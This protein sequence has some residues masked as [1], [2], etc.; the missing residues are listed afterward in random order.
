[1]QFDDLDEPE[2]T[3]ASASVWH[4]PMVSMADFAAKLGVTVRSVQN[5]ACGENSFPAPS[6]AGRGKANLWTLAQV[7]DYCATSRAN[8][9]APHRG[10]P[11]AYPLCWPTPT[12]SGGAS[13]LVRAQ[14]VAAEP[15]PDI[16]RYLKPALCARPD[17][18]PIVHY[19]TPGDGRGT[20][21]V[22]YLAGDAELDRWDARDLAVSAARYLHCREIASAAVVITD[23]NDRQ[24]PNREADSQRTVIV[25]EVAEDPVWLP[26]NCVAKP[27][28]PGRSWRPSR[29]D[30]AADPPTSVYD[31]GWYDLR[32]LLRGDVPWWPADS[33]HIDVVRGWTP[34]R[35]VGPGVPRHPRPMQLGVW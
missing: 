19:W 31:I 8:R 13:R 5:Y 16:Y 32:Y 12:S 1:M 24:V 4:V 27:T 18:M 21:A 14:F 34:A 23:E 10:I 26:W 30:L 25:A 22:V 28:S 11:R 9:R 15:V 3:L 20:L 2:R 6:A 7:F 29:L 17:R 35:P 33:R